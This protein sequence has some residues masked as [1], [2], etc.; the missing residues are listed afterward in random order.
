MHFE[1]VSPRP[2]QIERQ[3]VIESV[4]DAAGIQLVKLD[5]QQ[6]Y[7]APALAALLSLDQEE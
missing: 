1:E 7:T 4:L 6:A 5:P 3:R 2:D